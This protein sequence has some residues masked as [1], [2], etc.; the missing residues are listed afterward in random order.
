MM[1]ATAT[2]PWAAIGPTGV[3]WSRN[4]RTKI[5]KPKTAVITE[6]RSAAIA[7]RACYPAGPHSMRHL[8]SPLRSGRPLPIHRSR[9]QLPDENEDGAEREERQVP[10]EL[11]GAGS[12]VMDL[13]DVV[14]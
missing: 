9:Q 6:A 1:P 8:G 13:Q 7:M 5:S 2:A 12:H 11:V 14:I 4:R 10:R 3:S